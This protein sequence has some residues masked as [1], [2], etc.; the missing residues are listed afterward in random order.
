MCCPPIFQTWKVAFLALAACLLFIV[1]GCQSNNNMPLH[2]GDLAAPDS[3]TL[4]QTAALRITSLDELEVKVFGVED[5]SGTFQVDVEGVLK[6]PL[7]GAVTAMGYTSFELAA[8]LEE[9]LTADYL[10]VADVTVRVLEST[11]QQVTLQGAIEQPGLYPLPGQLTLLQAIALG[12]GMTD[13]ANEERVIVFRTIKGKRNA[14]AFDL[15][16]IQRGHAVDPPVYGNDLIVIDGDE[17]QQN[18]REFLRSV[19][20]LALFGLY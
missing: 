6:M 20:L 10:Q 13:E 11:G 12:G 9:R 19:P 15:E 2:Q 14:A 7:I 4:S 8:L 3:T 1:S 17:L 5:L 18:Y 16:A